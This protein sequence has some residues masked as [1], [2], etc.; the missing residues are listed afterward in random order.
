MSESVKP[1]PRLHYIGDVIVGVVSDCRCHS[2]VCPSTG[3]V[4]VLPEW[5]HESHDIVPPR[6]EHDLPDGVDFEDYKRWCRMFA[7]APDLLAV[8]VF[9]LSRFCDPHSLDTDPAAVRLK[10]MG[11]AALAKAE[12]N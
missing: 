1:L 10:E 9:A 11:E 4:S 3:T 6:A 12:G 2:T 5:E 7:A 8:V